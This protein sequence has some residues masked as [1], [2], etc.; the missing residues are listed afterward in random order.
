MFNENEKCP[1][2]KI[3]QYG[4]CSVIKR[5]NWNKIKSWNLDLYLRPKYEIQVYQISKQQELPSSM[6]IKTFE[7]LIMAEW[8]D[9]GNTTPPSHFSVGH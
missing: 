1:Y 5:V 6:T 9:M 2:D 4:C 8:K 3:A 7:K